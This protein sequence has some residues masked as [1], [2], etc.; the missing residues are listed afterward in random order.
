M[1]EPNQP[2][3][4]GA[5]AVDR[6]PSSPDALL[7]IGDLAR[8]AGVTPR[9]VRFYEDLGLLQPDSRSEGGF[10]LYRA[11]QLHRLRAVLA[12]KDVG[13]S[14]DDIRSY[15]DLLTT[16]A[17]VRPMLGISPSAWEEAGITMGE[18]QA[19]IVVSAIL[20][21][22]VAIKNPG[23]YLRNL[24]RRAAAGQFSMWPML[25][26]LSAGRLKKATA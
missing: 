3:D 1:D 5:D 13:F 19:A 14:L 26:A 7:K 18:T 6:E 23:G 20:Q 12:L 17:I 2:A 22:G 10:R 21:R 11:A 15:R 4:R 25:M 8:L 16:A 9:T 24:T